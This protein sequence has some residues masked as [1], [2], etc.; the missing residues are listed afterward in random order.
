MPGSGKGAGRH[1]TT[2]KRS[3]CSARASPPPGHADMICSGSFTAQAPVGGPQAPAPPLRAWPGQTPE[4]NPRGAGSGPDARRSSA[5]RRAARL[6]SNP[7]AGLSRDPVLEAASLA[8]RPRTPSRMPSLPLPG[9]LGIGTTRVVLADM[10]ADRHRIARACPN[11]EGVA[12]MVRSAKRGPD[13]RRRLA[14]RCSQSMRWRRHKD[15]QGA[16]PGTRRAPAG[17]GADD[18]Y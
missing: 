10:A 17:N 3:I 2:P 15:R 7:A 6:R 12:E 5:R 13:L 14:V 4:D 9:R 16:G 1:G 18:A 8:P 11:T